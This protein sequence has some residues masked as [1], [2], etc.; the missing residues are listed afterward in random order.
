MQLSL[1]DRWMPRGT[2]FGCGPANVQGLRLQSFADGEGV[3]AE[4]Q[5]QAHHNAWP[6]IVC[7]GIVG[8][9]LDC[10]TGAALGW[11]LCLRD[12]LDAQEPLPWPLEKSPWVTA[13]YSVQLRRPAPIDE[14]LTLRARVL[15]LSDEEAVIEGALEARGKIC[16]TCSAH[17][18]PLRR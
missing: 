15:K 7:G 18:K 11:A 9:L 3:V 17:W 2:C 5:A 14:S 13:G 10:H 4:W 8:T 6:G 1:Q 16:A 12:G